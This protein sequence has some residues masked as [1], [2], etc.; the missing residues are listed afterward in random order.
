VFKETRSQLNNTA[1]F[2]A[3]NH[4]TKYRKKYGQSWPN[5]WYL[6]GTCVKWLRKIMKNLRQGSRSPDPDLNSYFQSTKNVNYLWWWNV[7]TRIQAGRQSTSP[8]T[9]CADT[10]RSK[11]QCRY[12]LRPVC[13]TGC[14]NVVS[15]NRCITL[16]T[17]NY[18]HIQLRAGFRVSA[19]VFPLLCRQHVA[20]D[21]GNLFR[22]CWEKISFVTLPRLRG[23]LFNCLVEESF[24]ICENIL[25]PCCEIAGG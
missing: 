7:Y 13:P 19:I 4:G 24:R 8:S 23:T 9:R 17:D 1:Y 15:S 16:I 18:Y 20:Y 10:D 2:E 6:P 11:A 12:A 3:G 5:L 25:F 22:N 21:T 14:H